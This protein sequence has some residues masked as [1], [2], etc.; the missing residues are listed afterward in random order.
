MSSVWAPGHAGGE[1]GTP[2]G[3]WCERSGKRRQVVLATK[4]GKP[5]GPDKKGLSPAYI[6]SAVED[7]LRRLR[8]DHIDLYQTHDGDADTPLAN[9]LGAFDELVRAGKVRVG[10][11]RAITASNY[12]APRL[13]QALRLS[14]E[15]SQGRAA[16]SPPPRGFK[17]SGK[18]TFA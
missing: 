16:A 8:T 3:K 9:T 7:S 13:A 1:S 18:A 10:K 4:V 11:V 2:I 15:H 6:R 14:T 17:Q 5:M 12:S